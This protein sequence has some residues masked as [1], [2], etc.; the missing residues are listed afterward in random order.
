[1]SQDY[2]DLIHQIGK[3]KFNSRFEIRLPQSHRL[4]PVG[5]R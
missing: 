1:M 3:D 4:K 2:R 5:L